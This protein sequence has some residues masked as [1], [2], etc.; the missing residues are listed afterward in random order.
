MD[1]E[2]I[3]SLDGKRAIGCG[4]DPPAD[5]F[6]PEAQALACLALLDVGPL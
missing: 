1:F 5:G 6:E 3:D 4:V 2:I